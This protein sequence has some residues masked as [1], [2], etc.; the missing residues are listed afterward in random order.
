MEVSGQLHAQAPLFPGKEPTVL[1]G[2]EAGRAPE[3]VWTLWGTE[4]SL[5]PAGNLTPAE[6]I[7]RR[8]TD[9]ATPAPKC[10]S[11]AELTVCVEKLSGIP[12]I[13]TVSILST[14]E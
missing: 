1:I 7:A 13:S 6:P 8:Y 12:G 10:N 3:P 11:K 5:A 14:A 2:E 4:I 9:Q